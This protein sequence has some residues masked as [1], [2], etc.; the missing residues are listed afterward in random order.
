[1][2]NA[3]ADAIRAGAITRIDDHIHNL[4]LVASQINRLV[5][6][7]TFLKECAT[8]MFRNACTHTAQRT[9][10]SKG[11]DLDCYVVRAPDKLGASRMPASE[12]DI[13]PYIHAKRVL[14]Q[15][16]ASNRM[17]HA[18]GCMFMVGDYFDTKI[19]GTSRGAFFAATEVVKEPQVWCNSTVAVNSN[20]NRLYR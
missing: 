3:T 18:T 5:T 4:S 14:G 1:M 16:V 12:I 7:L 13:S 15:S 19:F 17:M 2:R 10:S 20:M 9:M 6:E 8:K 11:T